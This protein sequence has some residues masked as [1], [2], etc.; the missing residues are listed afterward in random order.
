[1]C[2]T[3]PPRL[4]AISLSP[5]YYAEYLPSIPCYLAGDSELRFVKGTFSLRG[6]AKWWVDCIVFDDRTHCLLILLTR[7]HAHE[8]VNSSMIRGGGGWMMVV[9]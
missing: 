1:M 3:H 2:F 5:K 6:D 9:L 7:V 8:N 4:V